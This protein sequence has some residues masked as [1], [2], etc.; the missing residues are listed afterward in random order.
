MVTLS[1]TKTRIAPTPSGYLHIGNVMSFLLTASLAKKAGA[2]LLLRIDDLDRERVRREYVED[3]F[4]TL[5]FLEI[6]WQEGPKDYESYTTNYSQVHRLKFYETFL[7]QLRDEGL[8][9]ACQCSRTQLEHG[10]CRC[11]EKK[12]S[13]DE[14]NTSWRLVTDKTLPLQVRT[15]EGN[16]IP[17]SLPQSMKS[18]VVRKKDGLPSYQLFSLV[19]DEHFEVNGIV[20]GQDLWD[21]TLAQ[22]YLA[23]LL[24]KKFFQEAVFYHHPLLMNEGG[25]DKLSKSA[26]ATSIQLLRKEGKSRDEVISMITNPAWSAGWSM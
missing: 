22:Q 16:T 9:F 19:D 23:L 10:E 24:K 13:L 15:M 1:F 6:E 12:I 14:T 4:E 7:Q 21:S 3:I 2:K 25:N 26:G 8:V 18:F 17:A 20:R 11:R 5:H